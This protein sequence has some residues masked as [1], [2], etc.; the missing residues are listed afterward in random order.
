MKGRHRGKNNESAELYKAFLKL[1]SVEEV[2]RFL[3][4]LCTLEEII[5]FSKRWQAVRLLVQHKPYHEVASK[6]GLSST[7]VARVAYWLNNGAGGYQLVLKR[8]K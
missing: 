2:K 8:I 1:K 6:T 5:E 7:T 3:R 4:D